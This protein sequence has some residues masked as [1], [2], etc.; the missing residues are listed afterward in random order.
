MPRPAT[1][2]Q[3]PNPSPQVMADFDDEL[4][5]HHRAAFGWALAC[6]A[7]D[8]GAAEDVLQTAYLKIVDGRARYANQGDFRAFLFGVIRRTA[9]EE[10]RRAIVRSVLPLT[11]LETDRSA[12]SVP[13]ASMVRSEESDELIDALRKLA[14]RQRE[15]LH[16]VF[17]HDL[18][19]A[20]AA[21]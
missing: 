12:P 8:R 9:S 5:R 13:H 19:I 15:V 3:S 17:Y 2:Q 21:D 14:T 1:L 6:C 11:V 7:W 10:R 18:T 20:A 4:A 16:L